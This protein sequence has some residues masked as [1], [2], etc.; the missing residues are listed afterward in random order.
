MTL[1]AMKIPDDMYDK[2]IR[3]ATGL[4]NASEAQDTK[5][6]WYLYDQLRQYC[7]AESC[8]GREHPF[9][10][11]TLAD[12]TINDQIAI[13][14]YIRALEKARCM[15]ALDYEASILFA[16]AERCGEIGDSTSAYRYALEANER[17]KVLDDLEL[18]RNI[19]AFLLSESRK[20]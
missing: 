7:E 9:L 18:R 16:L 13:G 17:A 10:W 19:S 12:Y 11:E 14:L 8:S 4:T 20:T 2:V 6:Y 1:G 5:G 3:F 15:G